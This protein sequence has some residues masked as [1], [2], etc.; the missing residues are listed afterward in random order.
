MQTLEKAHGLGC[1]HLVGSADGR[2]AASVGFGGEVKVWGCD[3]GCE[4]EEGDG[5][6]EGSGAWE[7]RGRVVGKAFLA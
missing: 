3:L 7:G 6:S 2:V 4:G 1:H 5:G